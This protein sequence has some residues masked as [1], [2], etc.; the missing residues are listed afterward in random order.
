MLDP[1]SP[2]AHARKHAALHK[3]GDYENAIKAFGM[4]FSNTSALTE[5]EKSSEGID[6]MLE[7]VH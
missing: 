2:L 4:I 3:A 6:I 7:F 1:L 5:A